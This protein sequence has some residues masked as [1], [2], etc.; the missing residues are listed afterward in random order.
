MLIT[1]GHTGTDRT[2]PLFD[3]RV[4]IPGIE[5]EECASRPAVLFDS[6]VRGTRYDVCEMS[7]SGFLRHSSGI[8]SRYV[9]IPAFPLRAFRHRDIYVAANSGIESP[10]D[11]VGRRIGFL[12]AGMTAV[13]WQRGIL[14]ERFGIGPADATWV[15]VKK[16]VG[17]RLENKLAAEHG[18]TLESAELQLAADLLGE[19]D[20]DAVLGVAAPEDSYGRPSM[21]ARRL[22]PHYADVEQEYYRSTGMF[23]IMH[24]VLCD[25]D[26]LTKNPGLD[27]RLYRAMVAARDAAVRDLFDSDVHPIISPWV[28]RDF[29]R[30]LELFGADEFWSYGLPAN[31]HCLQKFVEYASQQG[32]VAQDFRLEDF[33]LDESSW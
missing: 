24:V 19:G 22:F 4:E 9:A 11:L 13:V 28:E 31:Q 2:R 3:G 20:I 18:S 25:R 32:H 29:S 5:L 30:T 12:N 27:R 8:L 1:L 23:P 21:A 15:D 10:R 7:L 26:L 17:S 16:S 33:I 14:S 6:V